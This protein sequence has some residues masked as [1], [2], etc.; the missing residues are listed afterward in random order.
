[1]GHGILGG[2]ETL[3]PILHDCEV[4]A[5]S[6]LEAQ[7]PLKTEQMQN[8][9]LHQ[10]IK[11]LQREGSNSREW[12]RHDTN[13]EVLV[14]KNGWSLRARGLY[15]RENACGKPLNSSRC[16]ADKPVRAVSTREAIVPPA[17]PTPRTYIQP[18][19][20]SNKC[21]LKSELMTF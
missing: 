19:V 8:E 15:G 6:L 7:S 3:R 17:T 12:W 10:I 14:S 4:T 16:V 9:P 2:V 1:M 5:V 20:K 18:S 21:E 13:A 11:C